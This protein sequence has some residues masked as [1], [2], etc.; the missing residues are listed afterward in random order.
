M[1]IDA[2]RAGAGRALHDRLRDIRREVA[3]TIHARRAAIAHAHALRDQALH[4]RQHSRAVRQ[5]AR[6]CAT[7]S[8]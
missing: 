3:E 5:A 4:I 1:T 2:Q 6:P 7:A 8:A